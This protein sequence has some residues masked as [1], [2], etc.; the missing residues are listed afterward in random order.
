[1]TEEQIGLKEYFVFLEG[2][3]LFL[4]ERLIDD[5]REVEYGQWELPYEAVL[6]ALVKLPFNEVQF[7]LELAKKLAIEAD[8]I[9][10]GILS[11]DTWQQV[12]R[13]LNMG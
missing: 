9:E 13:W 7:D 11:M 8:I 5:A 4:D 10:C 3:A 2:V 12:Q 6:L 1:M